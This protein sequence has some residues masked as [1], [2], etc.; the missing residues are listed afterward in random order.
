[1]VKKSVGREGWQ[2]TLIVGFQNLEKSFKKLPAQSGSKSDFADEEGYIISAVSK[3][4]KTF[5]H[6]EI[7]QPNGAQNF[8]RLLHVQR[9]VPN[10]SETSGSVS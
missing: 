4:K 10:P 3:I 2:S 9:H 7:R 8:R 6:K 5:V 1:M